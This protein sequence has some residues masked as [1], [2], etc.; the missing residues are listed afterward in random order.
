MLPINSD[1]FEDAAQIVYTRFFVSL[2]I[3]LFLFAVCTFFYGYGLM[4]M[5]K[6]AGRTDGYLGFI[7]F[8]NTWYTGKL[9][10]E[11]NFFGQKMKRTGLYAMIAEILYSLVAGFSLVT[12]VL[13][14]PFLHEVPAT[15]ENGELLYSSI[16]VN[17]PLAR[18]QG[19]G[20]AIDSQLWVQ[21]LSLIL[22]IVLIVFFFVLFTALFK[23]YYVRGPMLL[24]VFST[25]FPFRAATVF[26]VRN[27][28]PIDY[29]AYMR[30]K[31]EEYARRQQQQYPPQSMY[32]TPNP[33]PPQTPPEDPFSDFGGGG[34]QNSNENGGQ[35]PP[36]PPSN[37][38]PFSDF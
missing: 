19:F 34:G 37:D 38:S 15:S 20:W 23:K 8:V 7:P 13:L 10:G 11:A 3:G 6:K 16:E 30:R 27:N 36:P 28:T 35:T 4:R 33:P 14:M 2:G 5:A 25:I 12:N 1:T 17:Q 22:D 26:A 31:M 32:G 9:A 24:T 21:I 18:E 29:E